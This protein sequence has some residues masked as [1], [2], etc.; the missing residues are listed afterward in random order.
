MAKKHRPRRRLGKARDIGASPSGKPPSGSSQ[1]A[2]TPATFLALAAALLYGFILLKNAWLCDDSFI[3]MRQVEQLFAGNGLRWNPHE[4]LQLFTSVIGFFLTALGRLAT[5]DYFLIYAGQ[6]LFFNILTLALLARLLRTPGQWGTAVLLLAAS[7]SYMDFTWAGLEN[8]VGYA[9]VATFLLLWKMGASAERQSDRAKVAIALAVLGGLAPLFRHDFALIIWPPMFFVL[10]MQRRSLSLRTLMAA[11]VLALLPLGLWTLFSLFYFGF[12]FPHSA[13]AKIGGGVPRLDRLQAGLNYFLFTLRNDTLT[14]IVILTAFLWSIIRAREGVLSDLALLAG[15]GLH[16]LYTLIAG[17]DYMGGRFFSYTYLLA[18]F[19]LV[20]NWEHI[21]EAV[22]PHK[23]GHGTKPSAWWRHRGLG[24]AGFAFLWMLAFPHTPLK[25]PLYYGVAGVDSIS[26]G[27][28]AD[29]RAGAHFATNILSYISHLRGDNKYYPH[30]PNGSLGAIAAR[31][32]AP[33]I[34]VCNIGLL[35][36]KARLDQ[37]FIDIYG[38]SDSLQARLPALSRRPGHLIR[39]LPQGYLLSVA[40]DDALIA[41][42]D[43]NAYYKK[44]RLVTQSDDLF[45]ADRLAAIVELNTTSAP[46]PR[47]RPGPIRRMPMF[48]FALHYP[49]VFEALDKGIEDLS[50]EQLNQSDLS[51]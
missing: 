34:H 44:V 20:S 11:A 28:I 22:F 25:T 43:L 37:I 31:S 10:W 42:R 12:P 18:V 17:A 33:V 19:V 46:V 4:R 49:E 13:Y 38:L 47:I 41:D 30:E 15:A 5:E 6:A 35:P 8:Y 14:P 23:D 50:M 24:L 2:K 45:A 51:S 7:N 9:L 26:F 1:L 3:L 29:E 48:C 40:S 39:Q 27:G 21:A 32:A 36:F 16:L